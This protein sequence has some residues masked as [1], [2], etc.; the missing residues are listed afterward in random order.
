MFGQRYLTE[1]MESKLLRNLKCINL[2][3]Y[4]YVLLIRVHPMIVCWLDTQTT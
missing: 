4:M 2:V 1:T 3:M